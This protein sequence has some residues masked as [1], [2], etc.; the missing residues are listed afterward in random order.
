MANIVKFFRNVMAAIAIA[1]IV[2]MAVIYITS[3]GD[4]SRITLAKSGIKYA[5]IG[6]TIILLAWLMVN[7]ILT[8]PIYSTSGPVRTGWSTFT[9]NTVSQS[10]FKGTVNTSSVRNGTGQATT[11]AP[12]RG[13]APS[14]G[15]PPSNTPP[16]LPPLDPDVFGCDR[17]HYNCIKGEAEQKIELW[18]EWI[19]ICRKTGDPA[20]QPK[21]CSERKPLC[22]DGIV[23]QP[24]ELCDDGSRNGSCPA[25]CDT[26]C[27]RNTCAGDPPPTDGSCPAGTYTWGVGGNSCSASY[28]ALAYNALTAITDSTPPTLGTTGLR[29]VGGSV[30]GDSAFGEATCTIAAGGAACGSVVLNAAGAPIAAAFCTQGY[31]GPKSCSTNAGTYS[32]TW[33]C[34]SLTG[35]VPPV[36]CSGSASLP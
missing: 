25:I 13:E 32:C 17:T 5:L 16:S 9:C 29:C 7:F 15:E 35:D 8:L 18:N 2:A 31:S 30:Q 28:G 26:N 20:T 6:V 24:S 14:G 19:W 11:D 34:F 3:A 27:Q 22:G 36:D 1:V 21:N 4:E 33:T 12:G 23:N 10:G